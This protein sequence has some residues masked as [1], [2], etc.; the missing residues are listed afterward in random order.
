MILLAAVAGTLACIDDD[1]TVRMSSLAVVVGTTFVS[2]V[3]DVVISLALISLIVV[4][5]F[6]RIL[7]MAMFRASADGWAIFGFVFFGE[8]DCGWMRGRPTFLG[9]TEEDIFESPSF[10]RIIFALGTSESVALIFLF[11]PIPP[12]G[13]N[14]PDLLY[15]LSA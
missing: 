15:E 4:W 1:G 3:Y 11:F 12:C 2:I 8:V 13:V 14:T 5:F 7:S 10:V 6:G 9:G